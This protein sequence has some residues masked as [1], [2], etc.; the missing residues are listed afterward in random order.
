MKKSLLLLSVS[1]FLSM[2][3]L[4][5]CGSKNS[6]SKKETNNS[7]QPNRPIQ[8]VEN[9]TNH[10]NIDKDVN[11]LILGSWHIASFPVKEDKTGKEI[12]GKELKLYLNISQSML[13]FKAILVDSNRILCSADVSTNKFKITTDKII[14]FENLT[15]NITNKDSKCN[16]KV[17][18]SE[19]KYKIESS[20]TIL[21]EHNSGISSTFNEVTGE[22]A[23]KNSI[24]IKRVSGV[25]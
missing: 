25:F 19:Y 5:G 12:L 23:N 17:E 7:A 9:I 24:R 22:P 6:D 3:S 13:A 21:L 20:D 10:Y 2:F 8:P 18:M 14:N 16:V 4:V 15:K 1:S 11:P